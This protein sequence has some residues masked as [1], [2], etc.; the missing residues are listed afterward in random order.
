M[1][2]I[3]DA[4]DSWVTSQINKR[5]EKLGEGITGTRSLDGIKAFNQSAPWIRLTSGVS[6]NQPTEEE[7]NFPG[8][9]VYDSLANSGLLQAGTWEGNL[10]SRNFILSGGV[11]NESGVGFAGIN[12]GQLKS[13]YGFGYTNDNIKDGQGYVPMPGITSAEFEYKNDGALAVAKISV[14]AYSK[15]QFQIID[16]LFQRPGYTCLLEF[17]HS[18]FLDNSGNV[19]Y[20]GKGNY[21]YATAPFN[22]IL[23]APSKNN[24]YFQMAKLITAERKKWH[25]NYEA[26]F[27]KI[28]KFN[29]KF[30]ED[31][32]YDI[33]VN[34]V[35][36]GDVIS[37]LRVNA[38]KIT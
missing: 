31:G 19:Q 25:G 12:N 17:G 35:G 30:N 7:A 28:T 3:G 20:A 38:P 24:N 5:Q 4:F 11:T 23:D 22:K 13:S 34:L 18:V 37:S 33:T 1:A 29:W 32:T 16:V 8:V 2:L 14:K 36:T 26:F 21:S 27:G 9:S 15:A 10:L 6:I